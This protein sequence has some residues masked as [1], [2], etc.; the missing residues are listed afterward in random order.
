MKQYRITKDQ[1]FQATNGGLDIIRHYIRDIDEYVGTKK[2]F[3]IRDEKTPS[4]AIKKLSDG[5]YVVADFGDDGKWMNGIALTQK[6]ENCEYGEA[7]KII[8]ERHGLASDDQIKS[9]YAPDVTSED[10]KPDQPDGEWY[11]EHAEDVSENH[12]R[13]IF[14]DKTWAYIEYQ[15]RNTPEAE[16]KAAVLAHFRQILLEQHWHVLQSYTIIKQ[17]KAITFSASEFYPI[18]RI[19]EERKDGK[20][21]SKIYQPKAKEKSRRFFY[22]GDFDPQF[23]HG[24]NQCV[25][26]YEKLIKEYEENFDPDSEDVKEKPQLDEIIYCTGGSD[27]LNFRALGYHVVYPSSEHFKLSKDQLYKLFAKTRNVMTC[28]DKDYTGQQQNHRLCMNPADDL[29]LDIRTIELPDQLLQYRDQYGRPCKDVRDYLKYFRAADLRNLL[30]VAK[31][32]RFW[33]AF[34]AYD[35]KGNPKMKNGKEIK[36]YKLSMER[37]LNFLVKNGFGRRKVNEETMEFIQIDG[38]LVRQIKPE[39]IKGFL[40]NFLRSRYVDEDLL[41][42]L[43]RSPLLSDKSF[44]SLPILDPD[45][46]DYDN[47]SQYMFFENIT[48]RITGEGI[49]E[50]QNKAV[51]KMVWENRILKHRVRKMEP[52]FT[53]HKN[54]DDEFNIDIHN[55]DSPFFRFLIQTS[56]IHWRTEL[57]EY[58]DTLP[59][60]AAEQYRTKHKFDIAGPALTPEQRQDQIQHLINKMYAF[61]YMMHRYKAKSRPWIVFG[62]DDTPQKDNGSYGGTGKSIFFEG[63]RMVKNLLFLDGK[64]EKL[65]EDNHV[66]EQVTPNTDVIYIDDASRNFPMERT[67]SMT[68]GDITVNPKGKTRTS[69]PFHTSPKLG[70]TTNFSP[71]DLSPSTMRRI[72]FFG[73]SN[74]YHVDKSGMFRENRQPIDDF[75]KEFWSPEY[76]PQEWELDF[77]FMA[78]CCQ[79]YLSQPTWIEAPMENIMD[80]SLTN[81]MGLNFLEWAEV[82]FAPESGRLDCFVPSGYAIEEYRMS[83]GIKTITPNGFNGKMRL[84]AQ[85][86]KL[87][88]NPK[89]V[90]NNDGRVLK[91]WDE[92]RYDQREKAW[93]K[94]DRKKTQSMLYLQ[95]LGTELNDIIYDPTAMPDSMPTPAPGTQEIDF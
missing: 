25:K 88:L 19:E 22:H 95:S 52:M 58:V 9:M 53:V 74:Y 66:F 34:P 42:V 63:V 43:H 71:D 15:Y 10:A 47:V 20:R 33:D 50:I 2:K 67:F 84:F 7:I 61:G 32:Y 6:F 77:N 83:S 44:E 68:T 1:I 11:F 37:V 18:F 75:G 48:W 65:F 28:P 26:A 23:L 12:L 55:Q 51:T 3:A 24:Y 78:Q 73:T 62:M 35:R 14:S 57:E 87:I 46:R 90:Q 29:Y 21:F 17:R 5:N 94:S 60:D 89:P 91:N 72:L 36:E 69:L 8:A 39:D 85:Y 38:N 27:A 92:L 4:C 30:K 76:T 59:A 82:F 40:I 31:M 16:R 80:R 45:F 49:E 13:I 41:N 64:N 54:G 79:L 56:R 81:T 93:N 70:V 86:K